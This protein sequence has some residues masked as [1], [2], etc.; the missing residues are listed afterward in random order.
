[1]SE[2][3]RG[4][5]LPLDGVTLGLTISRKALEKKIPPD[6]LKDIPDDV[7]FDAVMQTLD[8]ISKELL[9]DLAMSIEIKAYDHQDRIE[10]EHIMNMPKNDLPLMIGH[11]FT[12]KENQEIWEKRL[13][14]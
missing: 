1:M 7:L 12:S 13:K 6:E 9:S 10:K 8:N 11:E 2:L 3:I 5:V 4:V 14:S